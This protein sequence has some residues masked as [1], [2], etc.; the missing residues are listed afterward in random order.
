MSSIT[1]T[2]LSPEMP[3]PFQ[4]QH[5]S[6]LLTVF[7][8]PAL[9]FSPFHA[10]VDYPCEAKTWHWNPYASGYTGVLFQLQFAGR[11]VLQFT[12]H[13]STI[14]IFNNHDHRSTSAVDG[15]LLSHMCSDRY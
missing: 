5:E 2:Y 3:P 7:S 9:L 15:P 13:R 14:L 6:A 4:R 1:I 12:Y 8:H 10:V 11:S